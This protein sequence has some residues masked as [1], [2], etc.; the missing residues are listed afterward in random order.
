M[1]YLVGVH[2]L[3]DQLIEDEREDSSVFLQEVLNHGH[4]ASVHVSSIIFP[5]AV[6]MKFVYLFDLGHFELL[7][8]L[9]QRV[10]LDYLFYCLTDL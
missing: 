5:R 6:S 1:L 4:Q 8:L 2:P 7:E 9:P 3:L 10:S